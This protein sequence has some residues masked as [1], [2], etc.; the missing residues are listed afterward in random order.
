MYKTHKLFNPNDPTV[1]FLHRCEGGRLPPY[2][3]VR[4][5][6]LVEAAL[7]TPLTCILSSD[8]QCCLLCHKF[9]LL[10]YL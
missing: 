5:V 10:P 7:P 4:L 3:S 2:P 9:S 1:K 8:L 6:T